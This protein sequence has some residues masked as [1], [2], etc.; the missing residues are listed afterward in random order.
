CRPFPFSGKFRDSFQAVNVSHF[1]VSRSTVEW[2]ARI[3]S[4]WSLEWLSLDWIQKATLQRSEVDLKSTPPVV[5]VRATVDL[6]KSGSWRPLK[7]QES[8]ALELI[9]QAVLAL[10]AQR[11][12]NGI[13]IHGFSQRPWADP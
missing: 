2:R 3:K 6:R 4:G 10:K 11:L 9:S 13:W 5:E 8:A 12:L 1:V 7:T